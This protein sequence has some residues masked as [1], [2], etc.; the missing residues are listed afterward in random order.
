MVVTYK[1]MAQSAPCHTA[2]PAGLDV[3]LYVRLIAEGKFNEALAV[4]RQ[5]LPFPSVCGRVCVHPCEDECQAR[6]L[7]APVAIRAL[8]R[9]IAERPGAG[10]KAAAEM[11][12]MPAA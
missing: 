8:K 5:K 6:H 4:V 7:G 2:C 11:D 12:K 10:V 3:P 9:F 1:E